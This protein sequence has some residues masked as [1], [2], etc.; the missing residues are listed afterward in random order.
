MDKRVLQ[1]VPIALV[2]VQ[3]DEGGEV[4]CEAVPNIFPSDYSGQ[5]LVRRRWS[6]EGQLARDE[7]KSREGGGVPQ[8]EGLCA[9]RWLEEDLAQRERA[10]ARKVQPGEGQL[11][12][13]ADVYVAMQGELG[14]K[15]LRWGKDQA[16]AEGAPEV[17][18]PIRR[19]RW[20]P[21]AVI[22]HGQLETS[23]GLQDSL[24]WGR[25]EGGNVPSAQVVQREGRQ[26]GWRTDAE[27]GC[28]SAEGRLLESEA[29][30]AVK[31]KPVSI[32]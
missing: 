17:R 19:N 25:F 15:V 14:E 13:R 4:G 11:Q 10:E 21:S 12:R 2:D 30:L 28:E 23:Q 5:L 32:G 8:D 26:L 1:A 18:P 27:A 31:I 3:C 7:M 9:D 16:I 6:G 22:N 20:I 29:T 24:K